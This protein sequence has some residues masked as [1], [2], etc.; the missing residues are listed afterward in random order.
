MIFLVQLVYI[1]CAHIHSPLRKI[2]NKVRQSSKVEYSIFKGSNF[3]YELLQP[4]SNGLISPYSRARGGR[5]FLW[6]IKPKLLWTVQFS[7]SPTLHLG[8]FC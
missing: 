4:K 6:C 7:C 1:H 8:P 5:Y 3:N 2:L